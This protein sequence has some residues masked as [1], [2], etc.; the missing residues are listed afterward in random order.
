VQLLCK[1]RE[2]P[3]HHRP[4]FFVVQLSPWRSCPCSLSLER[5]RHLFRM[6]SQPCC[7]RARRG[8]RVRFSGDKRTVIDGP[9]AETGYPY[10]DFR[11]VVQAQIGTGG[12]VNDLFS[13]PLVV[14]AC[15][16]EAC[17]V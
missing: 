3:G 11:D 9:F 15:S 1:R 14:E 7:S 13:D 12:R 17:S 4:S 16:V 6:S 5:S 10:S 2:K 8:A